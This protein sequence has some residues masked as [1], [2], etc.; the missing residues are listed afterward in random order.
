MK[1][2]L[3]DTE[4]NDLLIRNG[5]L[6]IGENTSDVVET[7][8]MIA[9]GELKNVPVIGANL[10]RAIGGTVDPF[11]KGRVRTML[12]SEHVPVKSLVIDGN[13]VSVEI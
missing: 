4:T 8:M 12:K 5:R 11:F 13:N 2:I 3:R 6:V 10:V 9:P 7:V 1:G